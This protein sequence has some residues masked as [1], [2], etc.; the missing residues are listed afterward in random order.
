MR[1]RTIVIG[2]V[3]AAVVGAG[4]IGA[5]VA[6]AGQDDDV[7]Q[8]GTMGNTT[9]ELSLEQEDGGLEV[10]FELQSAAPGEAWQ[11]RIDQDGTTLVDGVR[12]TDDDA[13]LDVD[14]YAT[15]D[16]GTSTFTVTVV[17]PDGERH[18]AEVRG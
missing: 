4:A 16:S 12:N 8:R 15:D 18:T 3:A 1:K 11:V 2:A 6:W 14:A 10:N 7:E 9:Y 5:G 13:E 17:S